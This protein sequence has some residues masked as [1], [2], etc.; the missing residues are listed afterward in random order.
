MLSNG[1]DA[2][3]RMIGFIYP[4][5]PAEPDGAQMFLDNPR[6]D[7]SVN[8]ALLTAGLVY[9]A[10]YDTLPANLRPTSRTSPVRPAPPARA[11]GRGPHGYDGGSGMGGASAI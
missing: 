11:S 7:T 9:P 10:F 3:G 4:G 8:V 2:N 1:I 5:D 6:V